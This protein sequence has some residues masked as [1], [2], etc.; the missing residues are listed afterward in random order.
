MLLTETDTEYWGFQYLLCKNS[1]WREGRGRGE[2]ELSGGPIRCER[3]DNF[4][5][6][7]TSFVSKGDKVLHSL[8]FAPTQEFRKLETIINFN[9]LLILILK[10]NIILVD[11]ALKNRKM[12]QVSWKILWRVG[13]T[14]E[15]TESNRDHHSPLLLSD[16][17]SSKFP[18]KTGHSP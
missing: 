1:I 8:Y 12:G 17:W 7:F 10:V 15:E 9:Q 16:W 5:A 4:E 2:T 14:G 18:A 13:N 11:T 6:E 3:Q